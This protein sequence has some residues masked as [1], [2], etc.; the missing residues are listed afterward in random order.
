MLAR[1]KKNP[2]FLEDYQV[3]MKDVIDLCAEKVP[4]DRLKVHDGRT[5]YV[6][7]T[8]V[9]HP[10][11]KDQ[12][13]VVF[14]C[15]AQFDG[16]CLNDYLLQGPDQ[17]N[18]LLGECRFRQE[19]VAFMSDVKS[20]FHQFMVSEEHRDLLRFLWW[21]RRRERRETRTSSQNINSHYCNHFATIPR[22]LI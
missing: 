5:N 15:S 14:D 13:R 22:F 7:R 6:P 21:E 4:L 19:R 3:F 18:T 10:R 8:G 11:K 9:Y 17:L 20:M 16:V 12:I 2:K 1:F